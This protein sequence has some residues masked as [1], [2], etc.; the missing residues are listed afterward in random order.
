MKKQF[1]TNYKAAKGGVSTAGNQIQLSEL[2]KEDKIDKMI[3][4][5][6]DGYGW[7]DAD[8]VLDNPHFNLED[9]EKAVALI[10]LAKVGMLVDAD[11]L[12][13][14]DVNLEKSD[15]PKRAFMKPVD[16]VRKYKHL[17][18]SKYSKNESKPFSAKIGGYVMYKG[19]KSIL[20][21]IKRPSKTV[22][23]EWNDEYIEVPMKDISPVNEDATKIMTGGGLKNWRK[24]S[25]EDVM[26][27]V[28]W[29]KRQVP[30]SDDK[31]WARAWNDI[32]KQLEKKF[33]KR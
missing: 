23:I 20:K 6:K 13:G 25:P 9:G 11:K 26:S 2:L 7:I 8:Y 5:V 3:K 12:N 22:D 30:P 29:T 17:V 31:K 21:K 32:K 15:I 14:T 33:P 10:R 1:T 28:Y 27:F 19:T 4:H 18:Q 24:Y 16:V